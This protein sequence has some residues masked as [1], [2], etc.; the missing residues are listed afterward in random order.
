M[1][2]EIMSNWTLSPGQFSGVVVGVGVLVIDGVFVGV[3]AKLVLTLGLFVGPGDIPGVWVFVT[4]VVV[5]GVGAGDFVGV[6]V[7]I[8]KQG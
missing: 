5:V 8:S 7:G 4:V 3:E 6:I 1:F 2:A